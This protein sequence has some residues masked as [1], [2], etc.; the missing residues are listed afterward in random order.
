MKAP[1]LWSRIRTVVARAIAPPARAPARRSAFAGALFNRLT[2]DW[3]LAAS[4]SADA[5]T[6]YDLRVLRNRS[7][8]LV[9]NSPFGRRYHQLLAENV[10]G[11]T[12]IQLCAKNLT[13]DGKALFETANAAIESAWREWGRAEHCDVTRKLCL[14]ELLA[15][16]VSNW[17]TDGEILMRILRGPQFGPFGVA[18]QLLDVDFLDDQYYQEATESTPQIRQGVEVDEWGRPVAYHIWK[19][20][21]FDAGTAGG[22]TAQQERLRI[23]AAD[24]IHAFIP[25]RPGQSRGIPDAAPILTTLKMLDGYVEAELVAARTAS[26]SMGALEDLPGDETAT[27]AANPNAEGVD[28]NHAPAIA[29]EAEPGALL[30]LRGKR[31]RL[32]L[33][34]PQHPTS[35]FP[36]FTRMLSH[37]VAMGFGLSYGT[38]TGDLSQANYGSLRVGMLDERQHWERLQH[39]VIG[40]VLERVY[41]EWLKAALLNRMIAGI[42]DFDAARWSRVEWQPQGF[43]WI[44]P[45]KD[46]AGDLL[47]VAAGV[48][49]LTRMAAKRGRDLE[50]IIEERAREIKLFE[51]YD[52]PSTIATSITDRPTESTSDGA[53]TDSTTPPKRSF[54]LHASHG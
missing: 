41:R 12:G 26:A 23:P 9:R 7:R 46:A 17:G 43:D 40:H 3:T 10:I 6:R 44:D 45:L 25:L 21:P 31:A 30:D 48:S 13:K 32:A 34:D 18:L 38:L 49:S 15:L 22:Y 52:V 36:D 54:R 29:A 24:I 2:S 42:T 33:W 35:A 50:M 1:S 16:G 4:R 14:T 20:H 11:P 47:E 8:E 28:D 39:F 53:A 27:P 5:E 37:Y 19:R 51:Q